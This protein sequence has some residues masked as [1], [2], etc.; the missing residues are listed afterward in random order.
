MVIGGVLL[1]IVIGIIATIRTS[2]SSKRIVNN[3]PSRDRLK[4]LN[5]ALKSLL[6][7]HWP[8]VLLAILALLVIMIYGLYNVGK[9]GV[10]ITLTDK[11]AKALTF[12]LGVLTVIFSIYIVFTAVKQ[13]RD[14]N[15]DQDMGDIPNYEP[16][17]AERNRNIQIAGIFAGVIFL[18]VLFVLGINRFVK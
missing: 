3:K 6:G 15:Q 5:E 13:Y 10:N 16:N 9:G 7:P 8:Y 11:S 4:S 14:N 2:S 17:S 18:I 1:I 12:A